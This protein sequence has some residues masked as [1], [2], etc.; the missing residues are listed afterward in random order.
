MQ[1]T[2]TKAQQVKKALKGH[3]ENLKCRAD[4]G[5][6]SGWVNLS[7]DYPMTKKCNC[8]FQKWGMCTNCS[9]TQREAEQKVYDLIDKAGVELYSYYADDGYNTQRKCILIN[10]NLIKE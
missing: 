5:T 7:F 8:E 2:P 3:F 4:R 6:A 9:D 1:R 10:I